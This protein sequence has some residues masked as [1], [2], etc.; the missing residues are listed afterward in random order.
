MSAQELSRYPPALL[1][2]SPRLSS[3]ADVLRAIPL[4]RQYLNSAIVAIAVTAG[5]LATATLSAYAFAFLRVPFRNVVFGV[6]LATMMIPWEA[7]IIPNYLLMSQSGLLNTYPAL[8]LPFL[9]AGF[10]TFLLPQFFLS[11]PR[12]LYEAALV[13]GCGHLRFLWTILVPLSRPA[14]ASL[15]IYAFLQTWNPPSG[16]QPPPPRGGRGRGHNDLVSETIVADAGALQEFSA[17]VA[18]AMG[19]PDDVAAEVARHL[20]SANLSGHDSHG[21]LRWTQYVGELDRGELFPAARPRLVH[22]APVVAVF[23]AGRGFGQHSTMVATEWTMG[24]ARE[25][26]IAAAAIRHS[27]HIGRLGEYTER[28]AADGMVG[29]VTVGAAG[30]GSGAVAPFGGAARFLGTNPW[31]MGVP[32][33]GRPPVIYD[34]ATSTVAEG[35][36][37][38]ARA[39]GDQLA[40][41]LIRDAAGQPTVDPVQLYEGGSLTV[42]GGDVA[43]H[44]GH[45]LSLASALIGGLAMIGDPDPT[46]AGTMRRPETWG[47]R[48]AGV[49]LVAID[50][51]AFGRASDYEEA[52]AG[53]LDGLTS[54]PPAPGFEAVQVPGDPER[55]SRDHRAR[56]GVP[57]PDATWSDLSA[58]AVRFGVELR[59][60]PDR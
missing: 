6:F 17:A 2:S 21:V 16:L 43:G 31:S 39:R 58:I 57:V 4:A 53:V 54:V 25:H 36:V 48:L 38:L 11:F 12:D 24:R 45:G 35:K 15:G 52:V 27:M 41:G 22:E 19:A 18:G 7:V 5:Q 55:R 26:G 46:P 3:F 50:P 60:G 8:V 32:A 47:E 49:F 14:L 10:G 37:R 30:S 40:P 51:A 59:K 20:V 13:D 23:D 56:D 34:A 28:M 44:K 33:A 42:M 9:A 29:L 1:P